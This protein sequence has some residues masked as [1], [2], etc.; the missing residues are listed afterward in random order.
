MLVHLPIESIKLEVTEYQISISNTTCEVNF[1]HKG[2]GISDNT[3][4]GYRIFGRFNRF[5]SLFEVQRWIR[6]ATL[7]GRDSVA[8]RGGF[9]KYTLKELYTSISTLAQKLVLTL[10]K[11][12]LYFNINLGSKVS[13]DPP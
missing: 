6:A 13:F 1:Y 11:G 10:L 9:E 7:Q 2:L 3:K 5:S 8:K 12:T 4:S